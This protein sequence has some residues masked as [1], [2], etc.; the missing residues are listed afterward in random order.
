MNR[1]TFEDPAI[2]D[3]MDLPDFY[4]S[5]KISRRNKVLVIEWD[6]RAIPRCWFTFIFLSLL[7][8]VWTP[9]TLFVTWRL[10]TGQLPVGTV[11]WLLFGW[12]GVLLIPITWLMR[13]TIE[14]IEIDDEFY[15][16]YFVNIPWL[17]PKRWRMDQVTQ[18]DF[19]H[20]DEES[21][22]TLNVRKKRS[23]DMIAYWAEPDF[24]EFL[25]HTI[26]SHLDEFECEIPVVI[27]QDA[28]A[29]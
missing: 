26:Q 5:L 7:W 2:L 6:N 17:S 10:V 21:I 8:I 19:G 29:P 15:R 22:S 23:R 13:Y 12:A 4:P 25:F 9:I 3:G 18:I 1:K 28:C 24:R 14:R 11:F 27:F 20:S 16:H